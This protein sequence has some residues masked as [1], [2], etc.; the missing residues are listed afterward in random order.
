MYGMWSYPV[1]NNG[2]SVGRTP[3]YMAR[4]PTDRIVQTQRLVSVPP[5]VANPRI[6]LDRQ[7]RHV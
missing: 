3:S 6:A 5:I 7:R 1:W 4:A 2:A